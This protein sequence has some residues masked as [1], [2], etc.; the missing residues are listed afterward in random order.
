MAKNDFLSSSYTE[1]KLFKMVI[2][3]IKKEYERDVFEVR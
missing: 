3:A 2:Q 1:E